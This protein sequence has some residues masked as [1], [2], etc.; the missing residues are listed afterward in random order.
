[1]HESHGHA[2]ECF[3]HELFNMLGWISWVF[4]LMLELLDV[5]VNL[6]CDVATLSFC[7]LKAMMD[8]C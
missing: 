2:F 1:M 8:E 4:G 6:S 5:F 7:C 3:E